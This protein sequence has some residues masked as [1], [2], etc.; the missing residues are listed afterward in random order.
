MRN[1]NQ[2]RLRLLLSWLLL[3][4]F[5]SYARAAETGSL[6]LYKQLRT[7]KLAGSSIHVE[8]LA[9]D[10]DRLKMTFTGDFYFA[11][12]VD[13]VVYGAVFL[14]RGRIRSEA[15]NISEKESIKRFLNQDVVE[16]TFTN[17]VFRFTDDTH[18][19]L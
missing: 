5:A 2:A 3:L 9:L 16:S 11:E 17:A 14:G 1:L 15:S 19:K 8:N 7:F 18:Q 4:A 6:E 10:Q 12:P 13:G